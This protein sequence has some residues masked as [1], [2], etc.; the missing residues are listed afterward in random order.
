[1]TIEEAYNYF[2]SGWQ[3][4]KTLALKPQN[5]TNW[6]NQGYIP[7]L[8][9]IRLQL[10]TEGELKADKEYPKFIH[11]KTKRYKQDKE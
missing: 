10:L 5:W 9:Q 6:K 7:E 8:Q 1:M 2:G 3:I 4:C 11:T